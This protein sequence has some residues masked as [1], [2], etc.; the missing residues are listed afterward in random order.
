MLTIDP[1]GDPKAGSPETVPQ[2]LS[3]EID[4]QAREVGVQ[5]I[6]ITSKPVMTKKVNSDGTITYDPIDPKA[7]FTE[8]VPQKKTRKLMKS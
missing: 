2:K 3:K 8:T 5:V 4:K 1:V 6:D 7:D